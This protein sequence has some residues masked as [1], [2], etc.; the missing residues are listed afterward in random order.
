MDGWRLHLAD[1]TEQPFQGDREQVVAFFEKLYP[2][3]QVE[4]Y[5][6][7]VLVYGADA[8][9]GDPETNPIASAEPEQVVELFGKLFAKVG[10]GWVQLHPQLAYP[11]QQAVRRPKTCQLC[12]STSC[13]C[14]APKK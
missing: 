1:G 5:T 11:K 3:K 7:Q 2:G 8:D 13:D 4:A 10:D 6:D 9:L 12:Y 14:G